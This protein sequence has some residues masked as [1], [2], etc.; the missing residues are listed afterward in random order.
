MLDEVAPDEAV[1]LSKQVVTGTR[2]I[3]GD[4]SAKVFSISAEDI[5][6]R[7]ISNLEDL[8][9]TLPYAFGSITTQSNTVFGDGALDTDESL[10]ALG[11]GTSTVNLR[12]LGSGNTLVLVNGRRIAG[13]AGRRSNFANILNVPL[14]AV[15]RVDIQLDGASAVY[16]ADAIGGVV[17]FILRKDFRGLTATA[18]NE[19]SATDSDRRKLDVL[20]GF[21]WDT[22]NMSATLSRIED[23]PINNFKIRTSNDFRDDFGPEF[24]LR[25]RTV[26]QPGVVCE[27]DPNPFGRPNRGYIFPMCGRT[28]TYLQLPQ[29]SGV[30]ATPGDF[31]S[32]IKPFDLVTPQN[33]AEATT[34]SIEINAEQYITDD[35]RIYARSLRRKMT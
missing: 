26:G 30:G 33:G 7:G 18:R 32:E 19:W 22:G 11:L 9:R 8:F 16:G 35:L 29:G 1:E 28:A 25:S 4:P 20:G 6:R 34:S 27:F 17:N 24:D 21:A 2:L 23:K 12:A 15:E 13:D 31:S 5:S 14:A 3:G 10:G